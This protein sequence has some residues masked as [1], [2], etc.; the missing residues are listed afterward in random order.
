MDTE[1]DYK[2][3]CVF[4]R[5]RGLLDR[6]EFSGYGVRVNNTDG[7]GDDEIESI[8]VY[9][10]VFV[11]HVSYTG[12]TFDLSGIDHSEREFE[13]TVDSVSTVAETIE[14]KLFVE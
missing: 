6:T 13:S 1:N 2:L 11:V 7:E 8:S 3:Q 14:S 12:T 4:H 5:L 10:D 9:G